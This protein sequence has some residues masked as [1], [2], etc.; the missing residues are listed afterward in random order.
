MTS[1]CTACFKSLQ[2]DNS[3]T[4]ERKREGK[5]RREGKEERKGK[6]RKMYVMGE[7]VSGFPC[8]TLLMGHFLP[9]SPNLSKLDSITLKRLR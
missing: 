2:V 4:K 6:K 1:K 7:A 5:E 9:I 8:L 3:F